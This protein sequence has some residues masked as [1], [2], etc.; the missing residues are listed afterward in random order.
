M[1]SVRAFAGS[2][3]GRKAVMAVSGIILVGF[4]IGHVLGNLLVFKGPAAMN[5]YA[6][7]LKGNA[8]LLWGTP[9]FHQP[10]T[11]FLAMFAAVG[12]LGVALERRAHTHL[13]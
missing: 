11:P 1:G 2:T 4:V 13:S 5:E 7:F 6:A 8:A 10:T 12:V 3:V 9:R